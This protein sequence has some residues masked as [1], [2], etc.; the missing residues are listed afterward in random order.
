MIWV[1]IRYLFDRIELFMNMN[2]LIVA[3]LVLGI[4]L[5]GALQLPA[6]GQGLGFDESA[7]VIVDNKRVS[8]TLD[9]KPIFLAEDVKDGSAV[10]RLREVN[11]DATVPHVTYHVRIMRVSELLLDDKFH[12]HDGILSIR[13]EHI[14]AENIEVIGERESLYDAVI[15]DQQNPA[16]LKGPI[17]DGGLYHYNISILSMRQYENKLEEPLNFDLYAS[18]GKTSHSQVLDSDGKQHTLSIKTYYDQINSIEYDSSSRMV[19]FTMPL[20]W[21]VNY[22]SQ[23]PFVHEEVQIPRDFVELMANSY[24]GTINGVELSNKEVMIDDYS[25]GNMRIIHFIVP[26]DR[27]IDIAQKQ[28]PE[29]IAIFTLTPREIPRFPLEILSGKE[30]FL[31]QIAWSPAVIEPDKST[32]FIVTLRDPKTLD[33]INHAT[34]DFVLLKDGREIFRKHHTA[35]I[36]A[37]VQDYTFTKEQTGT[38]L[39]LI[40]NINNTGESAPLL[41]T[42]VPEFPAGIFIVMIVLVSAVIV[43]TKTR[44]WL[45]F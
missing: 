12:S 13:F 45:N 2:S 20:N 24:I 17:L 23:V 44:V 1:Y 36:G 9:M 30:N 28:K 29:N 26:K 6:F 42:V 32:K 18:I 10:I 38:I 8:I 15:A 11:T 40:E 21:N 19:T 14:D 22:L 5:I 37:I 31:L 7:S 39:L 27:L 25:A 16:T 33:T 4:L 41:V 35:P 34:A 3:L 43:I